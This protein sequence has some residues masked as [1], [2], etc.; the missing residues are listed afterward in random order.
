VSANPIVVV[1]GG[2]F[3]RETQVLLDAVSACTGSWIFAGFVSTDRPVSYGL[4]RD[5]TA[6]IGDDDG[7]L[8]SP[9]A[10]YYVV[11][12]SSPIVRQRLARRYDAVGLT[13]ATLIHPTASIGPDVEIGAGSIVCAMTSITTSVRV[14]AHVHIDRVVTVGHDAVIEDFATLHPASVISGAV[15]IGTGAEIGTNACVLQGLRVGAEA[16]IGAGAVVTRDVPDATTVVGV[17]ARPVSA[18]EVPG[19]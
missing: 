2:G 9:T 11:A 5:D 18:E 4:N 17:P 13:A 16:V 15:H 12:I 19:G 10:S 6:W 7:F 1:G 8:A 3:A 14:G